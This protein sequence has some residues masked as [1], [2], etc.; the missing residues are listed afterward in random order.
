MTTVI[1]NLGSRR[2]QEQ[3]E[4]VRAAL[5]A[6][7]IAVDDFHLVE[8]P[9]QLRRLA[10]RAVRRGCTLLIAGG[11]DGTMTTIVGELA[12]RETVLGVIPLGTGNS[13]AQTLGIPVDVDGAAAVIAAGR[14][15][16]VDLG[17]VNRRY[18]ANFATVGLAAE[19]AEQTPRS[20][21]S[22]LGSVAYVL[23]GIRPALEQ[24]PFRCELRWDG[25]RTRLRTKQLVIA[26]GRVYGH[27]AVAPDASIVDA[28]LTVLT[29]TGLTHFEVA[30]LYLA[31]AL[32]TQHRL[33]DAHQFTAR[34]LRVRTWPRQKISLDGE[35]LGRTP[36]RFSVVP[37]ALRVM[38]PAE[39]DAAG[40]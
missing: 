38:V 23:A 16:R 20:L 15:A 30:R 12:R 4:Q 35:P 5:A 13:F 24:Q 19:I 7:A 26:S 17:L 27:Q 32:G 2:S 3:A 1:V 39:F 25:N 11:G 21:K 6:H 34:E 40:R 37:G 31:I 33:P 10:Q 29:T 22:L 28:K 18:F 8:S 36:A 9:S 14:S